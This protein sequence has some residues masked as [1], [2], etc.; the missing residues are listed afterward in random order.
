[1]LT[2]L[3]LHDRLCRIVQDHHPRLPVFVLDR[4]QNEDRALTPGR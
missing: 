1:M 3:A 4:W 2:A